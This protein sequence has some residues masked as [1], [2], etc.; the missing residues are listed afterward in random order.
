MPK[1]T[2]K[3]K[4]QE[5]LDFVLLVLRDKYDALKEPGERPHVTQAGSSIRVRFREFKEDAPIYVRLDVR[6]EP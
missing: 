4:K 2:I 5:I 3:Q 1:P 6:G